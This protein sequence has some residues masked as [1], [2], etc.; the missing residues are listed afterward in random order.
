MEPPAKDPRPGRPFTEALRLLDERFPDGNR[1]YEPA[2]GDVFITLPL[3]KGGIFRAGIT[4]QQTK[5]LALSQLTGDDLRDG[6]LPLD[7][8]L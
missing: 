3:K 5:Y 7:W 2:G 8:P 6:H 4:W 1:E